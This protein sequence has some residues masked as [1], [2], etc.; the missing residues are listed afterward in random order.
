MIIAAAQ[1]VELR[2]VS[3][4][5]HL[6]YVI[7]TSGSTGQ[8][9]GVMI[10]HRALANFLRSMSK[11]PGI[12]EHD[13]LLAVTTYCF[14]IAVLELFLPLVTGA[15]CCVCSTKT[16]SDTNLLQDEIA[17]VQPTIMQAT[18]S[19]WTMLLHGGWRNHE[20][21]RVL[22]GGEPLS[23]GLKQQFIDNASQVWNMFGP[24]ETTIWSTAACDGTELRTPRPKEAT[25]TSAMRLKFVFVD[26]YFLSL[27]VNRNFLLAA[28][29]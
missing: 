17:R 23:K 2:D 6:A 20:R 7:Y 26:I 28:S 27:V 21:V 10:Q 12:D 22:C 8:P 1:G 25:A 14:D 15:C 4:P 11:S 5:T 19:T 18:P 3:Q 16:L 9:K 29:R 13:R 24:T